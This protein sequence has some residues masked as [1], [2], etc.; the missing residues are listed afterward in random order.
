ME[1]IIDSFDLVINGRFLSQRMTG[2]QRVAREF[3][4]A[5]DRRLVAGH[6]PGLR[7]KLVTQR[8]ADPGMP[9]RAIVVEQA[10]HTRGH[11][12]EQLTLPRHAGGAA[13]LCLGN[14]API[15]SLLG[16]RPVG[17]MLHDLAYRLF[18]GDYSLS[19]RLLH[20]TIDA[21][22]LRRARPLVT[23]SAAERA[24]IGGFHPPAAPRIVVAANG[25][26]AKDMPPQVAWSPLR[27]AAAYGL[28]VGAL[29]GRKNGP[30]IIQA[31]ID[32]A[33][34]GVRFKLVGPPPAEAIAIPDDVRPL[35]EFCGYVDD[36]TLLR[37]YAGA[38]LF[39]FPT[40]YEA[41]GLPPIEAMTIGC[42][43]VVSD[44]PVMR[45][46]CGEAAI[47]C[48]PHDRQSILGA[49]LRLVEQ[50]ILAQEMSRVGRIQAARFTWDRQM[51][52]VIAAIAREVR[53]DRTMAG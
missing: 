43:V 49:A 10:G 44:I 34:R 22:L 32:L 4:A 42:P 8:D 6:Y 11:R 12:W 40:F 51:E 39:L 3:V 46:R 23:V 2:V 38:S 21:V 20:R 41:S 16:R 26:W 17:V 48:D 35:I 37:L 13:L 53:R 31:A 18:P 29:S 19:Y 14:S 25:G 52:Q 36:A 24:V 50:P 1:Q 5:L 30:G 45:E 27:G 47:Y 9:L 33:R 7:V 15:L 28:Y